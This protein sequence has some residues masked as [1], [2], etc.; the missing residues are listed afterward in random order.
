LV[1]PL[2]RIVL[3]QV[4]E[5]VR[6]DEIVEGDDV[7]RFAEMSLFDEGTKDK[8]ADAAESVAAELDHAQTPKQISVDSY[9]LAYEPRVGRATLTPP[10]LAG[11][12]S[13]STAR[14]TMSPPGMVGLA[15]LDPPYEIDDIQR[16]IPWPISFASPSPGRRGRLR[17]R[18]CRV[19]R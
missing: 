12:S 11:T 9:E 13:C 7:D 6:G 18:C 2:D 8:A 19:W 5:V 4:S 3:Q 17:T 14:A 1:L 15:L 10:S 16:R